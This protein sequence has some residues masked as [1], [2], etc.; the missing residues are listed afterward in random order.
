[1]DNPL[2]TEYCHVTSV[3]T[4]VKLCWCHVVAREETDYLRKETKKQLHLK[5]SLIELSKGQEKNLVSL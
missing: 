1:M 5:T 2:S 4:Q 3:T